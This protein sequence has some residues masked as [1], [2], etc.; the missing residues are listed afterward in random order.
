M[1][2]VSETKKSFV[3]HGKLGDSITISKDTGLL[4]CHLSG[5]YSSDDLQTL[6]SKAT[7]LCGVAGDTHKF[8]LWSRRD[9]YLCVLGPAGS[10]YAECS[11]AK[12]WG[13]Y[14]FMCVS[15]HGL[16]T[17]QEVH[18]GSVN[19][20]MPRLIDFGLVVDPLDS[21]KEL[22]STGEQV[23]RLFINGNLISEWVYR[24]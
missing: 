8:R 20:R 1:Y 19:L 16:V 22:W 23:N 10:V 5:S 12:H 24:E 4:K 17:G 3:I 7:A 18:N 14:G 9:T 13:K 2:R 21:G 11:G 15:I 6:L